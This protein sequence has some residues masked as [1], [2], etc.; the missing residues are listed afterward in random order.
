MQFAVCSD[1]EDLSG[2]SISPSG[3]RGSHHSWVQSRTFF[4]TSVKIVC[5]ANKLIRCKRLV[6]FNQEV[7]YSFIS[8]ARLNLIFIKLI[9]HYSTWASAPSVTHAFALWGFMHSFTAGFSQGLYTDKIYVG[10]ETK[11]NS[12][13]MLAYLCIMICAQ[14]DTV[15]QSESSNTS[16][17]KSTYSS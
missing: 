6:I 8:Q 5:L 7:G 4:D 14:W 12:T 13:L 3:E 2:T 17:V 11:W 16:I 15:P 9:I 1:T 10:G